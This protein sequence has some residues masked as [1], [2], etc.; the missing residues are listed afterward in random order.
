MQSSDIQETIRVDKQPHFIQSLSKCIDGRPLT[1]CERTLF[2]AIL[3][4]LERGKDVSD[5]TRSDPSARIVSAAS[6]GCRI[7]HG[8]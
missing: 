7:G 2:G 6:H 1:Q 3:E 4:S 5:L 8:D